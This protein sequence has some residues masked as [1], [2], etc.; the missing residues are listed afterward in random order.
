[1][2]LSGT[3]FKAVDVG[4]RFGVGPSLTDG[5]C[6][7][8]SLDSG[9]EACPLVHGQAVVILAFAVLGAFCRKLWVCQAL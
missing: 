2:V 6:E 7:T 4:Q 8:L 3:W 5:Q 1:M 9:A